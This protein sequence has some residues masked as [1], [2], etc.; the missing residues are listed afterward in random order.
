MT[1]DTETRVTS[2]KIP[3]DVYHL[4]KM[5]CHFIVSTS[6]LRIVSLK[7]EIFLLARPAP[8]A[9]PIPRRPSKPNSTAVRRGCSIQNCISRI[10]D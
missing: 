8:F 6:Y 5:M 7:V 4:A 10:C 1:K 2:S 9:Y 3:P